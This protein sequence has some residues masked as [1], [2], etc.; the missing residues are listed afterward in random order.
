[1][2]WQPMHRNSQ[3]FDLPSACPWS[4]APSFT[5]FNFGRCLKASEIAYRLYILKVHGPLLL[6][7]SYMY[8]RRYLQVALLTGCSAP[9]TFPSWSSKARKPAAQRN[10][11]VPPAHDAGRKHTSCQGNSS[12]ATCGLARPMLKPPTSMAKDSFQI[13]RRGYHQ[14]ATCN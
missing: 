6:T 11:Y 3:P 13:R 4:G 5:S 12:R 8:R 10:S 2:V 1:M 7:C 14:Q 9:T